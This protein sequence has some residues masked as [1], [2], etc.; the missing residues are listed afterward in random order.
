MKNCIELPASVC[1]REGLK[2]IPFGD[3]DPEKVI[4]SM[5]EFQ[6]K[7]YV[8]TQKGVYVV[9]DDKLVRLE[10]EEKKNG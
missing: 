9:S 6:D 5:I 2:Y 3:S 7:I 10:F 4:V 8:A 1:K